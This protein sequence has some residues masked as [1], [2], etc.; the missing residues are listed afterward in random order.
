M[1]TWFIV[2]TWL[3]WGIN[4][5]F[6]KFVECQTFET[7]KNRGICLEIHAMLIFAPV[8]LA[9]EMSYFKNV[10]SWNLWIQPFGKCLTTSISLMRSTLIIVVMKVI[11]EIIINTKLITNHSQLE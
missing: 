9:L 1:I 4:L 5:V 7:W 10:L 2:I 11:G 8:K 3:R 6:V